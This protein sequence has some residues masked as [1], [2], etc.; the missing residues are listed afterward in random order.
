MQEELGCNK[1]SMHSGYHFENINSHMAASALWL[2]G[3]R[4]Q[5]LLQ[6]HRSPRELLAGACAEGI[7]KGQRVGKGLSLLTQSWVVTGSQR[8][9][10]SSVLSPG[11][12]RYGSNDDS[13]AGG[14]ESQ[15][16]CWKRQ[17]RVLACSCL[18]VG[19]SDL[20]LTVSGREL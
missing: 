16:F 4:E 14:F 3:T 9:L 5:V 7:Q 17:E 13:E 2:M 1:S 19:L 15:G 11:D 12:G 8:T 18:R 20:P 10:S 6:S